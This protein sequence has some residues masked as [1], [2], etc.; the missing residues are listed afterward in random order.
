[1]PYRRR[2]R[3]LIRRARPSRVSTTRKS[4]TRYA[5][6]RRVYR[7]SSR[8]SMIVPSVFVNKLKF[9]DFYNLASGGAS[10]F[11]VR[12]FRLNNPRDPDFTGVGGSPTG[13]NELTA[14]YGR[15]QVLAS[16][17]R[18]WFYNTCISPLIVAVACRSSVDVAPAISP[19]VQQ[20]LMERPDHVKRRTLIPYNGIGM[21][22]PSATVTYYRTVKSIEGR[23]YAD[24]VDFTGVDTGNPT[25]ECYWD[26]YICSLDGAAVNVTANARI[27][28]TYVIKWTGKDVS[29]TD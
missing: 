3:T 6:R 21:A 18:V 8:P 24:D 20:Y 25:R 5:R 23:S 7:C 15:Y 27:E 29:T 10:A 13:F 9:F 16:S 19:E 2:R 12:T 26:V 1:M 17:I 4:S 14:L 11:A 28:V 22:H